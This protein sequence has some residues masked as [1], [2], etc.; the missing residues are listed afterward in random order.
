MAA[1]LARIG[2]LAGRH[3]IAA[4]TVWLG[5]LA[6]VSVVALGGM[7]F[8]DGAFDVP[9]TESSKAMGLL[10]EHFPS[11]PAGSGE[12][13]L[14]VQ[15]PA[16]T[17]LT[18]PG[19]AD[20]LTRAIEQLRSL[21]NVS[22]VLDPRDPARP[23]L[24][25]DG[26]TAV[27]QVSLEGLEDSERET[28]Q[29]NVTEVAE[30][31]RGQGLTAEVGG[32][33]ASG[34]PEILGPS[35]AVGAGIAFLVLVLT[36]GSLVAAGANMLSALIGVATGILGI[37]AY[38]SISPIG[39]VTPILAVMLGLAVGIDYSLFILARFR[40]EL[41]EGHTVDV[42][43]GRATGT[44]GSSVV[45][46]GAT[47]IIALAGLTVVGI[48]FI[49]E[50]GLAAAF[51]VGVAVLMSL[52]LL[53]A[54]MSFM[55][56]RAL[57]KRDRRQ[58]SAAEPARVPTR[59]PGFLFRW[60]Q[61]VVTRPLVSV[62][63]G[64]LLL[65]VMALP[66]LSMKTTL[67]VPGGEDPESTQRAAYQ[68]VSDKFG[69]GSQDPLVVLVETPG[70]GLQERIPE[71]Q[72]FLAGIDNVALAVPAGVASSGDAAIVSVISKSGPLDDRTMQLVRDIRA[73]AHNLPGANLYVTG[74]TALGLDADAQLRQA[75]GLYVGLIVGLSLILLVIL[76]RSVLVPVVA[77]AGFLLSLGAG[78][79]A[80]T[81]VFQWGWLGDV[82]QAP[83]G[84]ALLSLLPIILTGILF[85]LAMDYQVFL[86]TRIQEAYGQ[87]IRSKQAILHGFKASAGVVVAAAGIMAAVFGG[88]ALSHSSL[89]GSIA[90][91]LAVGVVADAFIV[92]MV[93]VPAALA[94]LGR[95]AWWMPK[96]WA[97]RLPVLDVE[98]HHLNTVELQ[99]A[100]GTDD[101]EQ[102]AADAEPFP[103]G[104]R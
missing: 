82:I 36:F 13:Q 18:A 38:S 67:S 72:E 14:V 93:I 81:A 90:L 78:L 66:L 12:L 102:D 10:Q 47:V 49:G 9:G 46:A 53:P 95:S 41:R 48:P 86:V 44:A 11:T 7:K 19:P 60:A 42:A 91:A 54:L 43:I 89:V 100:E 56:L 96:S 34:I 103:V 97:A 24:S 50:M 57:S 71:V 70:G 55:G 45:F 85:G 68:I 5:L 8:S 3:R 88:F 28:V 80:T 74:A 21:P 75:L 26:T 101:A 40:A 99:E 73:E 33:L 94:L 64:T 52:T 31:V 51:A 59:V 77:T 29:E 2:R 39:N 27:I 63:G 25:V 37:L 15:S 35:E 30:G 22:Q 16:G 98:G 83:Q 23:Y 92:R 76:F 61:F 6:V 84:N 62:V 79:G 4:I 32:S 69:Q 58:L 1:F 65:I 87:G 104:R 17:G 20:S